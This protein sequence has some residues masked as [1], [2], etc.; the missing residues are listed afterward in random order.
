MLVWCSD[1]CSGGHVVA[2]SNKLNGF[3][4][5]ITAIERVNSGTHTANLQS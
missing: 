4:Y 2:G 1:S 5:T 3:R